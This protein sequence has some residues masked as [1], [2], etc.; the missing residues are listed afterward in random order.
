MNNPNLK[1]SLIILLDKWMDPRFNFVSESCFH[2]IHNV[3]FD[4][5][6]QLSRI[7]M[8]NTADEWEGVKLA[9]L[10]P[11]KYDPKDPKFHSYNIE[12]RLCRFSTAGCTKEMAPRFFEDALRFQ[13]P[14]QDPRQ[15]V[16]N[17]KIYHIDL[18]EYSQDPIVVTVDRTSLEV[19]NGTVHGHRFHPGWVVRTIVVRDDGIW[20]VTTGRGIGGQKW[21]NYLTGEAGFRRL[22]KN[23]HIY[24]NNK[25]RLKLY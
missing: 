15:P 7:D 6:K 12:T 22:D 8:A 2:K 18:G 24:I 20:I 9:Q 11:E 3:Y 4:L 14:F 17:G 1:D 19:Q 10:D 13:F 21:L 25:L 5:T 23:L 16:M